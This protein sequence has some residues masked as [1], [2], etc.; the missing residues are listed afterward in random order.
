MVE[1]PLESTFGRIDGLLERANN[2]L[3]DRFDLEPFG[4]YLDIHSGR[5]G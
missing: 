4:A 5:S 2:S 1:V 3:D